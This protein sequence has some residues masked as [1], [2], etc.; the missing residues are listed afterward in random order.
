MLRALLVR[1]LE[2]IKAQFNQIFKGSDSMTKKKV[3]ILGRRCS[4]HERSTHVGLS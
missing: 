3:V 2:W 4:W 1:F